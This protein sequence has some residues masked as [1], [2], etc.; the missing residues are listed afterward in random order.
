M[1]HQVH[2]SSCIAVGLVY[3][4]VQP[5]SQD[6]RTVG[7]LADTGHVGLIADTLEPG[8]HLDEIAINAQEAGD[9]DYG[10]AIAMGDTDAAIYRRS[11][12]C[13]PV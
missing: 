13:H 11:A 9:E 5:L 8:V 4:H 3:G 2:F 12:E 10:G 7:V 6:V 1:A